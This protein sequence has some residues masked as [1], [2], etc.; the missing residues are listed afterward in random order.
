[1]ASASSSAHSREFEKMCREVAHMLEGPHWR[2]CV[3]DRTRHMLEGVEEGLTNAKI[4]LACKILFEDYTAVRVC[5][6]MMFKL[7]KRLLTRTVQTPGAHQ[8]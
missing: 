4:L 3:C 8:G 7:F 6:R 5:Q 1:M 2:E